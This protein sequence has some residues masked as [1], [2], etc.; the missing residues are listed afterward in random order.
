MAVRTILSTFSSGEVRA[1]G[2]SEGDVTDT[3]GRH[4]LLIGSLTV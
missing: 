3:N 2:R 1:E 4:P